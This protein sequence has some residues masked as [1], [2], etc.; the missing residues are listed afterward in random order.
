[1]R[2]SRTVIGALMVLILAG[3]G[4]AA[5]QEASGARLNG[6]RGAAGLASAKPSA[7]KAGPLT[8]PTQTFAVGVS[9]FMFKRADRSLRTLVFYPALFRLE[10]FVLLTAGAT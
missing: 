9:E 3:C 1:M 2:T 10:V 5:S 8:A 6:E 7:T 4:G